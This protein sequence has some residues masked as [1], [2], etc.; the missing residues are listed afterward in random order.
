MIGSARLVLAASVLL[1]TLALVAFL[2]VWLDTWNGV[3]DEVEGSPG[4]W[5]DF[6]LPRAAWSLLL[7][8][9]VG[10]ALAGLTWRAAGRRG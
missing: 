8:L 2:A 3:P 9:P 10:I 1:L 6:V 4:R 5:S 7:G